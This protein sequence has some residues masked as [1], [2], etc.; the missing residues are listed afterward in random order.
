MKAKEDVVLVVPA[1]GRWVY[2]WVLNCVEFYPFRSQRVHYRE[3]LSSW[4]NTRQH[5][6]NWAL[7]LELKRQKGQLETRPTN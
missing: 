1:Q 6:L 4:Q 3:H 7:K 5:A 2:C